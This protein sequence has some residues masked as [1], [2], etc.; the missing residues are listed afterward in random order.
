ME[1]K[2]IEQLN[3]RYATKGF[4]PNKK[5]SDKQLE[6]LLEALRL[7]PSSF[8][9]QPWHFF[10]VT[11]PQ[12]R[13]KLKGH[14]WNQNQITDASHVVV[15]CRKKE[16]THDDIHHFLEDIVSTRGVT[17]DTLQGYEDIMKGFIENLGP[18]EQ[19]NWMA[20]QV[21]IA[22]GNLMTA[23]A[24]IGVDTCPMEGFDSEA[25]DKE[26]GLEAKGYKSVVVCPLGFRHHEDPLGSAQKVRFA[27][28][29]VVT[30]L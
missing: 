30:K 23:A 12:V 8:G 20:K 7:T 27:H 10:V 1:N 28:H 9:L 21:Y 5:I 24:L 11:D 19:K 13:E 17:R 16:M 14:S 4:D 26:L 6:T 2:L 25:Y 29:K 3:W 22:L 18:E 15:L